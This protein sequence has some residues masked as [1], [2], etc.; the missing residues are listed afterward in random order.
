MSSP[1]LGRHDEPRD[2]WAPPADVNGEPPAQPV[3]GAEKTTPADEAVPWKQLDPRM[4]LVKP[5][6]QGVRALPAIIVPLFV[7]AQTGNPTWILVGAAAFVYVAGIDWLMTRYRVG[8][9]HVQL[10]TGLISRNVLSI[11]RSRIRSV[12]VRATVMHRLLRLAVLRI[13]TGQ[14][15]GAGT[16]SFELDAIA[17][18]DVDALRE[19]LLAGVRGDEAQIEG[20]PQEPGE[21][22]DTSHD[23]LPTLRDPGPE[24]AHWS[25]KWTWYAPFGFT[26]VLIILAGLGLIFQSGAVYER[27]LNSDFIT[28]SAN[29][30]R[31]LNP[32]LAGTVAVVLLIVLASLIAMTRYFLT[33]SG[34]TLHDDGRTLRVRHGLLN[35]R[36]STLDRRRLRGVTVENPILLRFVGGARARAIMT[37]LR[38]GSGESSLILPDAPRRRAL[39]VFGAVLHDD[40][41]AQVPLRRHGPKALQRRLFRALALPVVAIAALLVVNAAFV[42]LPRWVWFLAAAVFVLSA[43]LG[44]DRYRGLGHATVPGWLICQ[45]GSLIRARDC[46]AAQG[47]IGWTVTQTF[48]QRR[49]GLATVT[50]ATPAGSGGYFVE[51]MPAKDAWDL[52]EAVTPGMSRTFQH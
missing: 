31:D 36:E 51:D 2:V 38:D 24:L 6:T 1:H 43:L 47:I 34:F 15:S 18:S 46:V 5:I 4:L 16:S 37:G 17:A 35:T 10:K 22:P 41:L 23:G 11:P 32:I 27:L 14:G 26:G 13:G 33:Y 19:Q 42:S 8:P 30:V 9:V 29:T 39:E 45:S 40:A 44:I 7:G 50:A 3:S 20:A 21:S 28:E 12:D 49:A 48:F 52:I 25:P